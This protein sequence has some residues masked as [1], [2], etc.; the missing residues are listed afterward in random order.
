MIH[1]P[2]NSLSI[3]C[4]GEFSSDKTQLFTIV[5][6]VYLG[7]L[8][9]LLSHPT[10]QHIPSIF[11]FLWIV[12]VNSSLANTTVACSGEFSSDKTQQLFTIVSTCCISLNMSV[13]P[14]LFW[15]RTKLYIWVSLAT[16][17]ASNST[18]YPGHL[19]FL[20]VVTDAQLDYCGRVGHKYGGAR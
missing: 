20:W 12:T 4:S 16:V 15:N 6:I 11:Y 2:T 14:R 1:D 18:T 19:N 9:R 17:V 13:I 8:W 7:F 3:A 5:S 10:A